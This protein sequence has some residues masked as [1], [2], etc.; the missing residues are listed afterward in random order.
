[1]FLLTDEQKEIIEISKNLKANEILKI[2]ACAGSGKTFTL[3]Q[4]AVENKDKNILYIAFNK[5]I[6]EEIKNKMPKNVDVKT[7]HSLA[8]AYARN[9]LGKFE[10]ISSYKIFDIAPFFKNLKTEDLFIILTNFENFLKSD[11]KLNTLNY[12]NYIWNLVLDYE[13]P[14]SHNFYLKYYQLSQDKELDYKYDIIMLDEAQDTNAT[15]LNI[16]L[17]N[18]CSKILV[19]DTYQNIYGFNKTINA[20]DIVKSDYSKNLSKNFRSKQSILDYVDLLLDNFSEQFCIKRVKMKSSLDEVKDTIDNK[21][22]ITRTNAGIIEFI[23]QI[24]DDE[25]INLNDYCLIKEPNSI[26]NI[27]FDIF[28]FM[29]NNFYLISKEN[30]FLKHFNSMLEL[31]NYAE[32]SLDIDLIRSLYLI[33]KKYDF[34]KIRKKAQELFLNNKT[35]KYFITNAHIS[36]GLEWDEIEL[37]NDFPDLKKI[38]HTIENEK[39]YKIKHNLQNSFRQELNLYYVAMTRAK[40]KLID[41]THNALK[42]YL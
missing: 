6:A 32:K 4:I 5:K 11:E 37:L 18:N 28:N 14:I 9:K 24:I 40:M 16:F 35:A 29:S 8:Y 13:I 38:K 15:M 17:N 21:A 33:E 39:N 22:Y 3:K 1:M 26:F 31:R 19:G 27:I 12:I 23:S 7:I 30:S 42:E 36:K 25:K 34:R 41:N 2:N 10:V 20:L